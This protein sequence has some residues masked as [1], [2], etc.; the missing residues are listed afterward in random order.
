[1]PPKTKVEF[2][3]FKVRNDTA[4]LNRIKRVLAG[5][6]FHPQDDAERQKQFDEELDA[7]GL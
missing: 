2:L 4:S 3:G 6:N 5:L 1:V 7:L